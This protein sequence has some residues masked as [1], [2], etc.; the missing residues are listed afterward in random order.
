MTHLARTMNG[1]PDGQQ[2]FNRF[3]QATCPSMAQRAWKIVR[4]LYPRVVP[5]E[6]PL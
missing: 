4:R 3:R 5:L 1:A 6:N 2:K